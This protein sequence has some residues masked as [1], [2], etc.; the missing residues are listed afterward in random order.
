MLARLRT[1]AA[2]S[3]VVRPGVLL[4]DGVRHCDR[5][6]HVCAARAGAGVG[7]ARTAARLGGLADGWTDDGKCRIAR[8]VSGGRV[9][10]T[11]QRTARLRPA[12]AGWIAADGRPAV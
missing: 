11:W 3:L 5:S 6:V 4:D 1:A 10:A 7:P 2:V 12:R 9:V 8:I